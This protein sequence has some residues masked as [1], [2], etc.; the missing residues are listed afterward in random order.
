MC[1]ACSAFLS[2]W[3]ESSIDGDDVGDEIG[4][5]PMERDDF[6]ERRQVREVLAELQQLLAHAFE[7]VFDG[8]ERRHHAVA[9]VDRR[10]HLG[11]PIPFRWRVADRRQIA[12]SRWSSISSASR[13]ARYC[14]TS[15][16]QLERRHGVTAPAPAPGPVAA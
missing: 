11:R 10:L 16:V 6:L 14:S 4:R 8:D 1:R 3:T 7:L 2:A 9:I 13:P 5:L 12:C 15:G